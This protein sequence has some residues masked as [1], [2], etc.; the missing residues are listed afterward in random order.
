MGGVHDGAG[1]H[2]VTCGYLILKEYAGIGDGGGELGCHPF[3]AFAVGLLDGKQC[4]VVDEVGGHHLV[5]G[6]QVPLGSCL[7]ETAGQRHVLLYRH[8]RS[9]CQLAFLLQR[10]DTTSMMPP[11]GVMRS[12][13]RLIHRSAWK[14]YSRKFAVA[15][16]PSSGARSTTKR[17]GVTLSPTK[18]G[19]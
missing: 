15:S 18:S 14:G 16:C 2:L 1:D 3:Y 9:P 12:N 11:G 10:V 4:S 8:R 17:H 7:Q 13:R 19:D 5:H 6:V